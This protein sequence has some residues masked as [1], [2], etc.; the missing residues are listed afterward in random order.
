MYRHIY[1]YRCGFLG[2][3]IGVDGIDIGIGYRLD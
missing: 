3:G 2:S 1:R